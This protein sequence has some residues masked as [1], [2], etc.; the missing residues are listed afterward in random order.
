[1]SVVQAHAV[2]D[3]KV[4]ENVADANTLYDTNRMEAVCDPVLA[5]SVLEMAYL[6]ARLQSK[7]VTL[8][9]FG[10]QAVSPDQGSATSAR[11]A[12]PS[13]QLSN[14]LREV[15]LHPSW[16]VMLQSSTLLAPSISVFSEKRT[17]GVR[18]VC[19]CHRDSHPNFS[20]GL[21]DCHAYRSVPEKIFTL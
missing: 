20:I 1:M 17:P 10:Q 13:Y 11:A 8:R 3:S 18:G 19:S 7:H 4:L 21:Y 5:D 15:Y 16:L 12:G 6:D 2:E 14:N 9:A